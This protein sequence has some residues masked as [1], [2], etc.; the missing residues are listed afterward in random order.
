MIRKY[1]DGEATSGGGREQPEE[2]DS[3]TGLTVGLI[4]SLLSIASVIVSRDLSPSLVWEA[5]KDLR[6]SDNM[7]RLMDVGELSSAK[8][9]IED[10]KRDISLLTE[11]IH[12]S[13]KKEPVLPRWVHATDRLPPIRKTVSI[14]DLEGGVYHKT[15]GW[16]HEDG[17]WII[18][19]RGTVRDVSK[20]L[21]LEESLPADTSKPK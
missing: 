11:A 3:E 19:S 20:I 8:R 18:F 15:G 17:F 6:S 4:D 7:L 21:W 9:Y 10:Q 1:Y 13:Q 16:R 2:C 14:H 12:L 5:M